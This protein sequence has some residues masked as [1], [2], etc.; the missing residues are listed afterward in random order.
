MPGKSLS[1]LALY[2]LRDTAALGALLA[3]HLGAV[4]ALFATLPYSKMVHGVYRVAA[5]VRYRLES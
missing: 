5:L 4:L 2:W 1:G 3:L